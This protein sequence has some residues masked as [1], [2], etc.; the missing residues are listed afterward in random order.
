M[1]SPGIAHGNGKEVSLIARPWPR[2]W[3]RSRSRGRASTSSTATTR[4]QKG[5]TYQEYNSNYLF[6]GVL[7][8]GA[9]VDLLEFLR[10]QK[11]AEPSKGSAFSSSAIFM[12]KI[13]CFLS[14]PHGR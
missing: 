13:R 7:L 12:L 9:G 1:V 3:I 10:K 8:Y 11:M 2:L 14:L 4:D 5:N 6:H